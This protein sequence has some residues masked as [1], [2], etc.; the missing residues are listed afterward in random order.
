MPLYEY[1]CGSCGER[2]E[3]LVGATRKNDTQKCPG[4]GSGD[5]ERVPSTFAVGTTSKTSDACA[6]CCP[7]GSCPL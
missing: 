5:T 3:A 7:G 4:C 6:T 1:E 2:F